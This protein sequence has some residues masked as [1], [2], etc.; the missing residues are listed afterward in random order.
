VRYEPSMRRH[1]PSECRDDDRRD[2][3]SVRVGAVMAEITA[4]LRERRSDDVIRAR[5]V[6][7]GAYHCAAERRRSRRNASSSD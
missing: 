6:L 7:A 2:G 4:L 1:P 3:L 5:E